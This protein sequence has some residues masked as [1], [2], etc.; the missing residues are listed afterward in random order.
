MEV[1]WVLVFNLGISKVCHTILKAFC[2]ISRS[3]SLF[4]VKFVRIKVTNLKFPGGGGAEL[5]VQK[6]ISSTPVRFLS[7]IG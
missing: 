7:E 2:R 4:S 1:L 6:S 3:G 5:G